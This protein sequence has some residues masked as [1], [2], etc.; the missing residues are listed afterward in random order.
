MDYATGIE[1]ESDGSSEH[2]V[3]YSQ[4]LSTNQNFTPVCNKI[5]SLLNEFG[6]STVQLIPSDVDSETK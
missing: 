1:L 3:T 4:L 6:Y 2:E 5:S